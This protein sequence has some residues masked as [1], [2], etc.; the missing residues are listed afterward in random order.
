MRRWKDYV[1]IQCFLIN[2][3]QQTLQ[4]LVSL[5][6]LGTEDCTSSCQQVQQLNGFVLPFA[7]YENKQKSHL[8]PMQLVVTTVEVTVTAAAAVAASG[9]NLLEHTTAATGTESTLN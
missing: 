1:V 8:L 7:A 9:G 6:T 5:L 3:K 4:G 2:K